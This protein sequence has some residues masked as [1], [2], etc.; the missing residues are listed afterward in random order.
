LGITT[1]T[2]T[3][4]KKDQFGAYVGEPN[5][6]KTIA[7]V[8]ARLDTR[9]MIPIPTKYINR[10]TQQIP[11]NETDP[12]HQQLLGKDKTN[13]RE[14]IEAIS[15]IAQNTYNIATN[16][17]YDK[18]S[19]IYSQSANFDKIVK[20]GTELLENRPD[21]EYK[22]GK[23]LKRDRQTQKVETVYEEERLADYTNIKNHNYKVSDKIYEQ[24]NER[25]L[26]NFTDFY[27]DE[28]ETNKKLKELIPELKPSNIPSLGTSI[29]NETNIVTSKTKT[30]SD[31]IRLNQVTD[32]NNQQHLMLGP[33]PI[34]TKDGYLTQC[35]VP[36]TPEEKNET[37]KPRKFECRI[38]LDKNK[39]AI[40]DTSKAMTIQEIK[41]KYGNKPTK[42]ALTENIN[43]KNEWLN[44]QTNL[45]GIINLTN[46]SKTG[47][48]VINNIRKSQYTPTEIAYLKQNPEKLKE[49][50]D[51]KAQ[52]LLKEIQEKIAA[53]ET[54][55][56][57]KPN[58]TYEQT[59][60]PESKPKSKPKS[61][62]FNM[63]QVYHNTGSI[64]STGRMPKMAKSHS[65]QNKNNKQYNPDT[66]RYNVTSYP[67]QEYEDNNAPE[68]DC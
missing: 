57:F 2:E 29:F 66:G 14:T 17:T 52:D 43:R 48:P 54:E 32:K 62:T 38:P 26:T 30:I 64:G 24:S 25:T 67:V 59:P 13:K 7:Y 6:N 22:S 39:N 8:E 12:L 28:N 45:C 36:V 16:K 60:E 34:Q 42:T 53:H 15:A 1:V 27:A 55:P 18:P 5:K 47:Q 35:Y 4:G 49:T 3:Y 20:A 44:N 33:I 65:E 56:E 40:I 11:Y 46:I 10:I 9:H 61:K 68:L 63:T 37:N 50:E 58:I 21:L 41:E 31:V 19:R 23:Y 51:Q